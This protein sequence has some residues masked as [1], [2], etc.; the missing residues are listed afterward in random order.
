MKQNN[1]ATHVLAGDCSSPARVVRRVDLELLRETLAF[2]LEA[3]NGLV[4]RPLLCLVGGHVLLDGCVD[5]DALLVGRL[6]GLLS[7]DL[8][9][10][11]ILGGLLSGGVLLL[12]LLRGD[13]ARKK[14]K[15]ERTKR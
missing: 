3:G 4:A 15:R 11:E 2:L 6:D 9:N 1:W 8:A 7:G 14:V 10:A 5:V 13:A 12:V